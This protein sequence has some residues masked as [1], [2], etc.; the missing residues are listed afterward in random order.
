MSI[1]P[2]IPSCRPFRVTPSLL[3]TPSRPCNWQPLI[4]SLSLTLCQRPRLRRLKSLLSASA[5]VALPGSTGVAGFP[6]PS[7]TRVMRHQEVWTDTQLTFQDSV[8]RFGDVSASCCV[9]HKLEIVPFSSY[10]SDWDCVGE[11][12]LALFCES[13]DPFLKGRVH[14]I[15]QL[16][17]VCSPELESGILALSP[18]SQNSVWKREEVVTSIGGQGLEQAS[19]YLGLNICFNY[20]LPQTP[21]SY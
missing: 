18:G 16:C 15:F 1:T 4:R 14:F 8:F 7:R 20:P 5:A 6:A 21:V 11:S 12:L 13:R 9:S 2:K 10:I 3:P 19:E 17:K